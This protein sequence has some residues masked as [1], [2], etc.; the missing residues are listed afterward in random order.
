MDLAE[1][2]TKN[3]GSRNKSVIPKSDPNQ[4]KI[5]SKIQ[6]NIKHSEN[7]IANNKKK[8]SAQ[9]LHLNPNLKS[10]IPGRASSLIQAKT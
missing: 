9:M 2:S 7:I 1:Y 5:I 6:N 8:V 4:D 3:F 10:P